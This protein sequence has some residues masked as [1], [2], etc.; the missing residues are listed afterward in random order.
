MI[1]MLPINIKTK[2]IYR[3]KRIK[4]LLQK[5]IQREAKTFYK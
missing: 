3:Q 4:L 1:N 5:M 2:N